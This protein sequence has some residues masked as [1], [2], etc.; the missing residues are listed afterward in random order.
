M[1]TVLLRL[2]DIA[3]KQG[4]RRVVTYLRVDNPSG[5]APFVLRVERW[6]LFRRSVEFRPIE[7]SDLGQLHK[8]EAVEE[9]VRSSG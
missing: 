8:P 1:P 3:R 2:I 9:L 6:R 4:L 7:P 5:F